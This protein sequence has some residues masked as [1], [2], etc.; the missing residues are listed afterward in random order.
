M[1]QIIERIFSWVPF[2]DQ[3]GRENLAQLTTV[4]SRDGIDFHIEQYSDETGA[5]FVAESTNTP[6]KSILTTGKD[7]VNLDK[8]IKDAIF[9]AYEIP[10]FLCSEN[11]IKSGL[12][13]RDQKP[14]LKYAT[15]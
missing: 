9:T 10:A 1:K 2:P 15:R 11:D 8:N 14:V 5:Y 13:N 4:L 3:K 12:T 6:G 7:L